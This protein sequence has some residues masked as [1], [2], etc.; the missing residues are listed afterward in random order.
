MAK[1]LPVLNPDCDNGEGGDLQP[2]SRPHRRRLQRLGAPTSLSSPTQRN[3]SDEGAHSSAN[4]PRGPAISPYSPSSFANT[5]PHYMLLRPSPYSR[6][7]SGYFS[8][9]VDR[10]PAPLS[11]D[12]STQTP[13]PP[14]QAL[15]HLLSAME[16]R[17]LIE[18]YNMRPEIW[19]AHELRRIG[20]EFNASHSP[21]RGF[22]D[23]PPQPARGNGQVILRVLHFI[24]RLIWRM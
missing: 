6:T 20:D 13:S 11:C 2:I 3:H 10:S 14:C 16:A 12:K 18:P 8:F 9:E 24:I 5:S 4:T 15:Q 17:H 22:F 23:N 19:I 7:S 1:Q 21:R